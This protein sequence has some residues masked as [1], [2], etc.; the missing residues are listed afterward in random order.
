MT[1]LLEGGLGVGFLHVGVEDGVHG[2]HVA[3]TRRIAP[4]LG[5]PQRPQLQ[6]VQP[7]GLQALAQHRLGEARDAGRATARTS[8]TS[9]TS[10]AFSRSMTW[11]WVEPS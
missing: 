9:S 10:A 2:R 6:I 4:G 1:Q 5:R 11:G 8:A 3:L 7:L